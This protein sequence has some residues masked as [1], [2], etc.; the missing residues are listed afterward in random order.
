MY[1]ILLFISCLLL[2][3]S[4]L[5]IG[6]YGK[7]ANF[8]ISRTNI[9][10][11]NDTEEYFDKLLEDWTVGAFFDSKI[12]YLLGILII[13]TAAI[14]NLSSNS[15]WTSILLLAISFVIYLESSKILKRKM[16]ILSIICLLLS[17]VL[18]VL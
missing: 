15:W 2:S 16:Q 18:L 6:F 1:D 3:Y 9:Y 5:I 14:I 11:Q 7:M 12:A 17:V 10:N 4:G 13:L 8:V